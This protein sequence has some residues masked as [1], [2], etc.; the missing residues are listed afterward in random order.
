[1]EGLFFEY[2]QKVLNMH[3]YLHNALICQN[4]PKT[5]P[6]ITAQAK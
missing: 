6:K 1:M 4:M 3:E 5:K 2:A